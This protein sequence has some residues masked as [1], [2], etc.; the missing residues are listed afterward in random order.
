MKKFKYIFFIVIELGLF[1]LVITLGIK[2]INLKFGKAKGLQ[3]TNIV[4]MDKNNFIYDTGTAA[5]KYFYEPKPNSII[6]DSPSWLGYSVKYNANTD[7][8][9][10]RYNYSN[11]KDTKTFKIVTIGDSWTQ[12]LYVNTPENFSEVLEDS[13]NNKIQC[14]NINKF[15]VINLGVGGYDL[16]Y[17]VHRFIK[18][19]I[20]YNPD[21]VI[22]LLNYWHFEHGNEFLSPIKD[23]LEKEGVLNYNPVTHRFEAIEKALEEFKKTYN[24]QDIIDFETKYLK[25]LKDNYKG[26]I[27]FLTDKNFPQVYQTIINNMFTDDNNNYVN[28]KLS[29]NLYR[30][31]GEYN[32]SDGHPSKAGHLKIAED[33][34]NY[35]FNNEL[36]SCKKTT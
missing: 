13:L 19:G 26:K 11:G 4:A 12:G 24:M 17:V 35:L 8:L 29:V 16:S 5:L 15:E 2:I 21:I 30:N 23:K 20:K 22:Y 18:R 6:I 36:S 7:S 1:A 32:L 34:F 10:D 31:Y 33:I 25:I 3:N 27:L 9:Y 14:Q 28:L